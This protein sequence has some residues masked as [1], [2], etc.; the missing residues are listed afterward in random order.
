MAFSGQKS[1]CGIKKN[2]KLLF[3]QKK[4]YLCGTNNLM[5]MMKSIENKG[6]TA[7]IALKNEVAGKAS[8]PE[9]W[10]RVVTN[11]QY[12]KLYKSLMGYL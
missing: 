8:M 1:I 5:I 6:I 7:T 3:K 10:R 11:R 12:I 2:Q 4:L 9:V